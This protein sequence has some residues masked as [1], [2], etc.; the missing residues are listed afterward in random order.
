[1]TG[2][3]MNFATTAV[4]NAGTNTVT[5]KPRTAGESIGINL[6]FI[7]DIAG[8]RF[9]LTDAE[10]DRVTAERFRLVTPTAEPSLSGPPSVVPRLPVST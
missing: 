1:M 6:G 2:D 10:L 3:S 7:T 8:L 5:L 4:I 9:G